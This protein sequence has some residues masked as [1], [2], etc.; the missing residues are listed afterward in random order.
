[1]AYV[2]KTLLFLV[3]RQVSRGALM[4]AWFP[5]REKHIFPNGGKK[6]GICS[7]DQQ[8][9]THLTNASGLHLRI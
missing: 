3:N 1:M 6:E 8:T 4:L 2:Q 7:L 5:D 9:L